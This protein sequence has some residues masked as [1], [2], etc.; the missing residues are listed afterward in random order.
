MTILVQVRKSCRSVIYAALEIS[1]E[2][3]LQYDVCD[4]KFCNKK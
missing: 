4:T 2:R 3:I 1:E